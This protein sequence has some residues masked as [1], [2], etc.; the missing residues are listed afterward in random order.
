MVV[1]GRGGKMWWLAS[2]RCNGLGRLA[3]ATALPSGMA[4]NRL[5]GAGL[6]GPWGRGR[7]P[8]GA[9]LK[10]EGSSSSGLP[11]TDKAPY[12]FQRRSAGIRWSG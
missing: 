3:R 8:L 2:L 4:R 1:P 10:S 5:P 7:P 11:E 6:E 9:P 12:P